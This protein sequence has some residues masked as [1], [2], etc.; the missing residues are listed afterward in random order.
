MIEIPTPKPKSEPKSEPKPEEVKIRGPR[1]ISDS[2]EDGEPPKE[3][4]VN[5]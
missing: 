2:R 5:G 4:I 3:E 1:I